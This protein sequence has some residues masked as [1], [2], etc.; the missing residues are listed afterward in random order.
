MKV[1]DW[2]TWQ[3]F[4]KDRGSPPW[5]KLH[6]TLMTSPK[7]AALT[8]AEKGQLVSL[9]IAAADTNGV[10]PDSPTVLRKIC[11]L[12]QEPNVKKFID[13]GLLVSDCQPVDNHLTTS[14]Q[15]VDAPEQSR[16]EESREEESRGDFLPRKA[17]PKKGTRLNPDWLVDDR[18][19]QVA[20]EVAGKVGVN[21]DDTD[22]D[23]QA[24]AFRDYW[25]GRSGQGATKLDW[26]ATWRT[27]IRRWSDGEFK[28]LTRQQQID[29]ERRERFAK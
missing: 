27:W 29:T 21:P 17:Q 26:D 22:I 5:I 8:D 25:L 19:R 11:Q 4:R 1:N 12:D 6:R 28:R 10:L 3:T 14:C 9:W 20:I 15:P 2:D 13:L 16:A 23:I 24:D 18:L 7:W